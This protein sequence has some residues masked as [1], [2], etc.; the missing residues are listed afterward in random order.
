MY[1]YNP[2]LHKIAREDVLDRF[3]NSGEFGYGVIT[4]MPIHVHTYLK[5]LFSITH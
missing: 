5:A 4:Y 3:Q 1:R 2:S